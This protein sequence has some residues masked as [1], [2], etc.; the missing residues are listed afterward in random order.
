MYQ[1]TRHTRCNGLVFLETYTSLSKEELA[2]RLP[3]FLNIQ[4]D[5]TK[6]PEYSMYNLSLKED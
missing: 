5:V 3:D 1:E 2:K 6:D 4:G